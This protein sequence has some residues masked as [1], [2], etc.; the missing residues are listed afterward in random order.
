MF[1]RSGINDDFNWTE[2]QPFDYT[3]QLTKCMLIKRSPFI[4]LLGNVISWPMFTME[5]ILAKQKL[6]KINAC[7][8]RGICLEI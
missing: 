5:V 6:A 8:I 4:H 7:H 3:S 1:N 2:F